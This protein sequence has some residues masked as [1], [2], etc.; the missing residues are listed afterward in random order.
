MF[1]AVKMATVFHD[2]GS[3]KRR[4]RVR[5]SAVTVATNIR[6]GDAQRKPTIRLRFSLARNPRLTKI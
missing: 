6:R 2:R 1:A 3:L 5:Y 4:V